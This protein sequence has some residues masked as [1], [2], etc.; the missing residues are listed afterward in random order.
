[1]TVTYTTLPA[2]PELMDE[3]K[4]AAKDLVPVIG[5]KR[6]AKADPTTGFEVTGVTVDI[7]HLGDYCAST[8][9]RLTNEL[10]ATY[11]YVLSFPLAMKVM[12]TPDFP[13]NAVGAVHLTNDI[14]QTRPLTVDDVLT[15]RTRAENL[16][17]HRK[18][19]LI[20]MVTEVFVEDAEG[21]PGGTPV[22]TQTS[23][24]LA[25]GAKLSS[26]ADAAVKAR[27][28]DSGSLFERPEV[29]ADPTP[30]ATW[31]ANP[32]ITRYYAEASGDKNPIHVS[33]LGAKAFGFPARIAHGMWSAARLLSGLEGQL[34]TGGSR[35]TVE[36]AKPV[37]LPTKVAFFA[38]KDGDAWN[39][40]L[41]KASKLETL[42]AIGRVEPA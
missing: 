2:V 40:Q 12:A 30:T 13:F 35:F 7:A 11:P 20:D 1:M 18:G 42:H 23:G 31:E 26:S 32:E 28:E 39:L 38:A 10:P 25:K 4:G 24:F 34:P 19:L 21:N 14:T 27:P 22:W 16:R 3:Y 41:R 8:G 33:A 9:L 15:V 29:P 17:T 6:S 36:F 37:V 5:A